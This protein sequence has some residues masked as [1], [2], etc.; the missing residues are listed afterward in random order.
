MKDTKSYNECPA[1]PVWVKCW[2][3]H[4]SYRSKQINYREL[5]NSIFI[6]LQLALVIAH[7][8]SLDRPSTRATL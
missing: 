3:T 1:M 4:T 2:E 6:A 5:L 7:V 8:Y